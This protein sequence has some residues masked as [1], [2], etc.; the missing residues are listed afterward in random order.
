M[1]C[2]ASPICNGTAKTD[3]L[4][5]LEEAAIGKK[6]PVRPDIEG[7]VVSIGDE[8]ENNEV[9]RGIGQQSHEIVV[10]RDNDILVKLQEDVAR[11]EARLAQESREDERSPILG[12][13][14]SQSSAPEQ[15]VGPTTVSSRRGSGQPPVSSRRGSGLS[16]GVKVL[17]V[18]NIHQAATCYSFA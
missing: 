5:T 4:E 14:D 13:V 16:A 8:K 17:E 6:A 11:L 1:D 3:A 10:V 9:A 7:E 2:Y 12:V 18:N 15:S